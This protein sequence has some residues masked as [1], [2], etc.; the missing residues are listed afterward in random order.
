MAL[1]VHIVAF[2]HSHI[3]TFV[4]AFFFQRRIQSIKFFTSNKAKLDTIIEKKVSLICLC[5][6]SYY[7]N[8]FF[9]F[10]C[11]LCSFCLFILGTCIDLV[12]NYTCN[13]NVGFTG[14]NC[15]VKLTN[16]TDDACYP[17]VTCFTTNDTIGCGPC[18]LGFSGDGKNCEGDVALK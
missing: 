17:N 10:F 1:Y 14:P 4:T 6:L 16:C 15:D 13:C 2:G 11:Y 7:E 9:S 18:P 5:R 12:N 8:P 3:K